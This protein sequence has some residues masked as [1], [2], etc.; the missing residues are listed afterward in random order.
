MN[1]K[2]SGG[3]DIIYFVKCDAGENYSRFIKKQQCQIVLKP[4]LFNYSYLVQ[5]TYSVFVCKSGTFSLWLGTAGQQALKW[6]V[7]CRV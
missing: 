4:K 2:Q 1:L 5:Q 3:A 6:D 7:V